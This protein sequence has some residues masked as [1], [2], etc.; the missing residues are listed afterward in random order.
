MRKNRTLIYLTALTII[1]LAFTYRIVLFQSFLAYGNSDNAL[2]IYPIKVLISEI[3]K[4]GQIPLWNPYIW[5]GFPLLAEPHTSAFY[6]PNLALYLSLNPAVAFNL[7]FTLH[8][9][10][11]MTS[12]YWCARKFD[13]S[14]EASFF[15][16]VVF[17]LSDTFAATYGNLAA[18]SSFAWI[19][20]II[21]ATEILV[22]TRNMNYSI[23]IGT[24]ITFQ[25]LS[26]FPQSGFVSFV[27]LLIYVSLRIL[28]DVKSNFHYK[29]K[30]L[31]TYHLMLLVS[32]LVTFTLSAIQ[33]FPTLE[34][35]KYSSRA[36]DLSYLFVTESSMWPHALFAYFFPG[37]I[38][39]IP[40]IGM[41][42]L[43]FGILPVFFSLFSV[44]MV[45]ERRFKTLFWL[46]IG[47][48]ILALGKFTPIYHILYS[49]PGFSWFRAPT[50][51]IFFGNA[52]L[53]ILAGKG[54]D[55]FLNIRLSKEIRSK[56]EKYLKYCWFAAFIIV[57]MLIAI[58]IILGYFES[59]VIKIG[60]NYVRTKIYGK[61]P[62]IFSLDYYYRQVYQ[63]YQNF[64][65][66]SSPFEVNI[67]FSIIFIAIALSLVKFSITRKLSKRIIFS[68]VITTTLVDLFINGWFIERT[69]NY[70]LNQNKSEIEV[71]EFFKKD[72]S[73]Y[74]IYSWPDR[75]KQ[76]VLY[77]RTSVP[78]FNF[79]RETVQPSINAE[80][81]LSS[82][83]GFS[84]LMPD[85]I[86]K[87][88]KVLES[89]D[90]ILSKE[91]KLRKIS[92]FSRQLGLLN[93]KYVI[94]TEQLPPIFKLVKDGRVKVYK[95]P[96]F[97]PRAFIARNVKFEV[98][99]E[100]I[101]KKM[102]DQGFIPSKELILEEKSAPSISS[103][104]SGKDKVTIEQYR[105]NDVKLNA[106]L[107]EDG[108][109]I[110]SD[111]L[112]PGWKCFVNG[113]QKKIYRCDGFLRAVYLKKGVS[114]VEFHYDPQSFKL[115]LFIESGGLIFLTLI[116]LGSFLRK[117]LFRVDHEHIC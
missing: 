80:F 101:L 98:S 35:I 69:P 116:Y 42:G 5:C 14:K 67:A 10:I 25:V 63:L 19:P 71:N 50:R 8:I 92:R 29:L 77:S 24:G 111:S 36:G 109:L 95:N 81:G 44:F 13:L 107:E 2:A 96:D 78:K 82:I 89:R 108:Y 53:A 48:L 65:R 33:L 43:Y 23:L 75:E 106:Q 62:H 91:K 60:M 68:M 20:L 97:L 27:S 113:D 84:G 51:F 58:H 88:S 15:S 18:L 37:L 93:V 38:K 57:L 74:R 102:F 114:R 104:F 110:L 21:G 26:G 49:L 86:F 90:A 30:K 54:L 41:T 115:G 12:M 64:Y 85:R 112:Y 9:L 28:M 6:P 16:S 61:P 34:L 7:T 40:S 55:N 32:I 46:F 3:L 70:S 79:V 39:N 52:A 72:K 66:L 59:Y 103:S 73:L 47:I 99:E 56:F 1:A 4:S 22:K 31:G 117:R 45:K 11:A 76:K 94:S 17:G 105:S 83:D 87:F 100:A